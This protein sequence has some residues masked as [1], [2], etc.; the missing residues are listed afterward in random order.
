MKVYR[1][2]HLPTGLFF[3]PSRLIQVDGKYAKSNLSKRGK[4]YTHK[5]T[6][7]YLD[8]TYYDHTKPPVVWNP[9]FPERFLY[10]VVLSEWVVEEIQ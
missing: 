5:P 9:V 2:K 6:L 8:D 3:V 4:L 10:P 1:I 7:R